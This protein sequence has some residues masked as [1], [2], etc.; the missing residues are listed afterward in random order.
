M[1]RKKRDYIDFHQSFELSI[2]NLND[3]EFKPLEKDTK[4]LLL[5]QDWIDTYSKKC[6]EVAKKRQNVQV[7]SFDEY[8]N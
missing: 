6:E 2:G 7:I 5:N 8:F 4:K 3:Y 1:E